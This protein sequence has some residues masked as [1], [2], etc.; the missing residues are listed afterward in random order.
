MKEIV[1]TKQQREKLKQLSIYSAKKRNLPNGAI[2]VD[3]KN[4]M[5][6]FG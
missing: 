2:L 6:F 3:D 1:L 5:I 4:E